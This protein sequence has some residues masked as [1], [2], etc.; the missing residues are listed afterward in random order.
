VDIPQIYIL[1]EVYL[2]DDYII[3]STNIFMESNETIGLLYKSYEP[4][5]T[6]TSKFLDKLDDI[7]NRIRKDPT[8]VIDFKS[9]IE[10]FKEDIKFEAKPSGIDMNGL[11]TQK[12]RISKDQK[13][14]DPLLAKLSKLRNLTSVGGKAD[15]SIFKRPKFYSKDTDG[16]HY[17]HIN[18][19]IRN[20]VRALDWVEKI[21]IDLYNMTDQDLNILMIISKEY[22]SHKIYESNMLDEDVEDYSQEGDI[23]DESI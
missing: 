12:N 9:D 14:L 4:I 13:S 7:I 18:T 15:R 11:K 10:K 22:A 23:L 2:M 19:N 3:E 1:R 8:E 17:D 6:V 20:C 5:I 21:L 16:E